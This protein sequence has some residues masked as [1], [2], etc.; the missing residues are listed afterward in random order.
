MASD[1]ESDNIDLEKQINNPS[2]DTPHLVILG[3]G[4]SRAAC[5]NGDKNG[6]KLPLMKELGEVLD[7]N[8]IL[9]NYGVSFDGGN[10]EEFYSNL[11]IEHKNQEVISKVEHAVYEY[12]SSLEIPDEPTV[13]DYLVLS[14]R[15][16]D[17]IATFNWDPLLFQ[18]LSRNKK[19][20]LPYVWFLHGNVSVGICLE[21]RAM[22]PTGTN[23]LH[24]GELFTPSKLLY[25]IKD[26]DYSND[27]F[28]SAQW[29]L[30]EK[31]LEEAFIFTIF[32]YSAP[33]TDAKAIDIMKKIWRKLGEREREEVEII[34]IE[35]RDRLYDSWEPFIVRSH[36][37]I[38]DNYFDSITSNWPRRS[39]ER[40]WDQFFMLRL[41]DKNPQPKGIDL[42]T[43]QE[44]HLPLVK[45]EQE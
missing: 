32:G 36:Y 45:A 6:K 24:C 18:A 5:P 34:N 19:F 9:K 21:H 27:L 2:I 25:P 37:R 33:T 14:L 13:Y 22:G 39:C 4:A 17:V 15:A 7:I 40:I 38:L 1:K 41:I 44:W 8:S 29:K 11:V 42:K 26:K 23:C 35:N 12:F 31:A 28:I 10:F 30:L 43:L 20:P 3:A 16:K